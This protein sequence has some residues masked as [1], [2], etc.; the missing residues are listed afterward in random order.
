MTFLAILILL[1]AHYFSGSGLLYLFR[2]KLKPAMQITLSI[3][4]G[5]VILSLVPLFLE[6]A[7]IPLTLTS[8]AAGIA[9]IC[10]LLNLTKLA[11]IKSVLSDSKWRFPSIK[12]YEIPFFVLFSIMFFS[13]LWRSFYLPSNAR[14]MLSGP[15][16]IADYAVKEHSLINSV[17]TV[18]LES[19]NNHLKPPFI[20]GLQVI[21]KFFGIEFGGVWVGFMSVCFCIFLYNVLREKMHGVIA[22]LLLL[23]FIALP[24]V[25]AYSYMMLFDYSNMV[26][27]FLGVYFMLRYFKSGLQSEIY[28]S[29]VLFGFSTIIRLE[30]LVLIAMMVPLLWLYSY[31]KKAAIK[32]VVLQS[33]A[34]M[35]VSGFFYFL[36]MNIFLNYYMPGLITVESQLNKN[37]I[38]LSPLFK[39]FSEMN[40]ELLF[41]RLEEPL[42]AHFIKVFLAVMVLDLVISRKM[43]RESLNWLYALAVVYFGL[44]ILGYLLPLM[45]LNNTTKRALFKL[46][47]IALLL[48]ANTG[49]LIKLSA[50]LL[51][52]ENGNEENR[53]GR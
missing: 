13:S 3:I 27:Y 2:V 23:L 10:V 52:W 22:G 28:F 40:S 33:F 47:P 35:A 43:S 36:W 14:D 37:L 11:N 39:R 16:V 48:M 29:A 49:I 41:G 21:Y 34:I 31:Q 42:W 38:D 24:E 30:T 18:N 5:I 4:C 45:D 7:F 6:L 46:M 17:L 26:L 25:Y 1:I 44:P 15:E 19:T 9:V 32:N 12:A 20:L 53:V 50:K 8:I 51:D